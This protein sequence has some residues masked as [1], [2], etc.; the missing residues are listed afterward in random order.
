MVF[1][2]LPV[3]VYLYFSLYIPDSPPL[4]AIFLSY[5]IWKILTYTHT[6]LNRDMFRYR[7]SNIPN[8]TE[9]HAELDESTRDLCQATR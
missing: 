7:R 2:G 5:Q 6:T 8:W 3:G 4:L 1:M 9:H